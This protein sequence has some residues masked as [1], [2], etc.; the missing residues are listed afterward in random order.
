MANGSIENF[1][2]IKKCLAIT[3]VRHCLCIIH[4]HAAIQGRCSDGGLSCFVEPWILLVC[5][6]TLRLTCINVDIIQWA[7]CGCLRF[8][9][10][11]LGAVQGVPRAP[12]DAARASPQN[13]EETVCCLITRITCLPSIS[14]IN[15]YE[16]LRMTL[17]LPKICK[18]PE[19][20]I[21]VVNELEE[22]WEVTLPSHFGRRSITTDLARSTACYSGEEKEEETG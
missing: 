5:T 22:R 10:R 1:E 4:T 20:M 16:D 12:E 15:T 13:A 19:A 21:N 8:G 3:Q 6:S 7:R 11:I 2:H 14:S 18:T 17:T 9:A